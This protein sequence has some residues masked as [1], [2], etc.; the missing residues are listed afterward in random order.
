MTER[1]AGITSTQL[2]LSLTAIGVLM[3][4]PVVIATR[5]QA[6]R[7]RTS[8]ERVEA[9]AAALRGTPLPRAGVLATSGHTPAEARDERWIAGATT[10]L[11][12]GRTEPDGWGNRLLV[13]AGGP[14]AV[15]VLSAGPNGIVETAF[16][17]TQPE[18]DDIAVRIR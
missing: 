13:N 3:L 4:V 1:Q 15:W 17:G 9:L 16:D 7:I 18:G 14:G 2:L 8:H 10:P 6:N 5:V 11:R 12:A